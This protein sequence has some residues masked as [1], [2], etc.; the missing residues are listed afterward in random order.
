MGHIVAV[1]DALLSLKGK[2]IVFCFGSL[3]L[4]GAE[5]QGFHLAEYLKEIAG[6]RVEVWG[7]HGPGRL[8]VLC[9]AKGI[10]WRIVPFPLGQ[11][12]IAAIR[13]LWCFSTQMRRDRVDVLLP[14]T[15][16]PNIVCALSAMLGGATVCAWNQRDEGLERFIPWVESLALRAAKPIIANSSGS[17]HF[18]T[19]IKGLS[20]DLVHIVPNGVAPTAQAASRASWRQHLGAGPDEL[21]VAMIANISPFKDHE[22]LVRAWKRVRASFGGRARLLLAGNHSDEDKTSQMRMLITSLDLQSSVSLLGRVDDISGF[23]GAID[24]VVHSSRSEGSPN[25][26]IEAMAAGKPIIGTDIPGVRDALG[27]S[28]DY[29]PVGDEM[30]MA[31]SILRYLGNDQLR[32]MAGARNRIIAAERFSI[33]QMCEKMAVLISR[34]MA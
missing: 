25:A 34:T 8:A 23:L 27:R 12:G 9:D 20:A 32:F 13:S 14:Y 17:A 6:A 4:G 33:Q 19:A 24:L 2:R 21:L 16:M 1:E 15:M 10:S 11:R 30:A 7:F 3:E 26:V 22:T 5:R 18:L 29:V 28:G 31:R